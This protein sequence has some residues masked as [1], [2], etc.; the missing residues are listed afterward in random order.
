M[1]RAVVTVVLNCI[2]PGMGLWYLGKPWWGLLNL[3]VVIV[4]GGVLL[5]VLPNEITTEYFH[6]FVLAYSAGSG[7]LAHNFAGRSKL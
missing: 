4:V 5:F 3:L 6:Y 1:K 2:I 7:R